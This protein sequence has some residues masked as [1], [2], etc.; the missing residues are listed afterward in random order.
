MAAAISTTDI[1]LDARFNAYRLQIIPTL[2]PYIFVVEANC[3]EKIQK[4]KASL[5]LDDFQPVKF[6]NNDRSK[7][8]CASH[9][10]SVSICD[11]TASPPRVSFVLEGHSQPVTESATFPL[12]QFIIQLLH[13][14]EVQ[15]KALGD[16]WLAE[17]VLAKHC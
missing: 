8:A 15:D 14:S 10:G 1:R 7:L 2:K 6:A 13:W 11:V 5:A 3:S 4:F 17:I 16:Q 9:D 12:N